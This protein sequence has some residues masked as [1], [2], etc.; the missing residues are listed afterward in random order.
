MRKKTVKRILLAVIIIPLL[1]AGY[2]LTPYV[3]NLIARPY[4]LNA[5]K[6]RLTKKEKIH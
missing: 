4:N 2:F 5:Y 1:I 3:I 6:A